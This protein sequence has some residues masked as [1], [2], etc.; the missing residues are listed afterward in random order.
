MFS[1]HSWKTLLVFSLFVFNVYSVLAGNIDPFLAE[2]LKS[3]SAV[4]KVS[5]IIYMREQVDLRAMEELLQQSVSAGERIPVDVRY[6]TIITALQEVAE[7]TQPNFVQKLRTHE[8]NGVLS[9]IQQFWI[10]NLVVVSAIQQTI[11]EI[12]QLPEVETVYLDGILQRD[13]PLNSAPADALVSGSEP[14]LRAIN[15]H[16]LWEIG[17][18]GLGRIVMNIDTGVEGNN[19]AYK[20]R[21]RGALPGIL[22]TWAWFD[23][24]NHTI[25]PTDGDGSS[26]HGTHTMGIMCGRYDSVNDTLGVA[27]D[28]NWIASNSLIGGSPHTSR[29]IASFQWAA[30]PDSNINTMD[31]VPDAINNSWYDPNV[32]STEC[33]GAS[34]YYDVIDAIEA[35]GTAVVFS[36]GN[37]GPG[38]STITPP[39]NR[40]TTSVNIFSV[41]ALDA[42]TAGYP[43]ASFSSRGPSVCTGPDS[44]RIKPEVSAPG[45]NVRSSSGTNGYRFLDGTSMAAPHVCGAIALLRQ[46]APFLTGTELKY[47]LYNNA[48][49]LGTPGED[50]TFGRGMIDV[51][52]TY[53]ALPLNIGKVEGEIMSNGNPLNGVKVDFVED[54]LQISSSTN[55][56]GK[57]LVAA[58]IDTPLTSATYTLRAEKF[59]FLTFT[60]TVTIL[61]DDTVTKNIVMSPAPGG[62]LQ[63]HTYDNDNNSI[64]ANVKVIFSGQTVINDIT[65]SISG[66]YSTPLPTGT[67]TVIIDAPSPFAT[68]SNVNVVVNENQTTQLNTLLRYV[69]EFTPIAIRDTL[70][71]GQI[72]SK[73]LQLTNTTN[74]TVQFRISDDNALQRSQKKNISQNSSVYSPI[75]FPKGTEDTRPGYASPEG[76]GGPDAFGYQWIDSDEPDGPEFQWID[77]SA[78]GT[79]LD[80]NST[81]IPTGTFSG[82]DEGYVQIPLSFPFGFYGSTFNTAYL[83]SNGIVMFKIPTSNT[84]SNAQIPTAGGSIDNLVA[85]FWDDLEI[86]GTSKIYYGTHSGNFVIQWMNIQRYNGNLAEYSYEYILKPSGEI[87]VQYLAMGISGGT[88]TSSTVGIENQTGTVGLQVAYNATYL[89][90]ELAIRFFTP[91]AIWISEVPITGTL[92]PHADQ[93]VSV[94]FNASGLSVDTTYRANLFL[95]A[96]HPDVIGSTK[97]PASLRIA[98]ADSA[99]LLVNK[100]SFDFGAVPLFETRKE[101]LKVTNGGMTTLIVSSLTTTNSDY[102][103]QPSNGTITTGN[104]INVVVSYHPTLSGIDTGR[105]IIQSNSQFTPR[106]DVL[107]NGSSY[108]VAR[109]VLHP[110]TFSFVSQATNDTLRKKMYILNTGSDTLRYFLEEKIANGATHTK[111]GKGGPDAFGYVWRDSDEPGGPDFLWYDIRSLGTAVSVANNGIA[112]PFPLGFDFKFYGTNYNEVRITGNGF[113]G[114]GTTSIGFSNTSIPSSGTPNNALFGFWEDLN[115]ETAGG[116]VHYFADA[117]NHLFIVQFTNVARA[118]DAGSRVTF[119]MILNANG[120]VKFQ[121]QSM[122]GVLNSATIGIENVTGGVGLLVAFNQNYVHDNL[123]ILFTTDQIPWLSQSRMEGTILPGDSQAVDI[124][125]HPARMMPG[126]FSARVKVQGNSPDTLLAQVNLEVLVGVNEI[127]SIIPKRFQ[128]FQNHPNPFNPTT[129]ISFGLPEQA[130]ISLQVFNVLGQEVVTLADG[131][132][133]AGTYNVEW[134]ASTALSSGIYFYRLKVTQSG[135]VRFAD[136]KKLLLLK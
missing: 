53:L 133:E 79:M 7:R 37:N 96:T 71:I 74:D 63:V 32:S 92:L 4:E 31:D 52:K 134:N 23:P 57:Y 135:N 35:L 10:R 61:L 26:Q 54:I 88:L 2:K 76:R 113:L 67:Y 93:N 62:T 123:A 90:N 124:R 97:I 106:L 21:W 60:D 131:I 6:R 13:L 130:N 132:F 80:S 41:G 48:V 75:E 105:I 47:Y 82:Q 36:A 114:F 126:N 46:A 8:T 39:K 19:L 81:W 110:N 104:S 29:S 14:G 27:P 73:Q 117:V 20:T 50:N 66:L 122:T 111:K 95:E 118:N 56:E 103:V 25:F 1:Y 24:A 16:K 40:L 78:T 28:A 87:V 45:V 128:L 86:V 17:I 99:L 107:L 18:T 5:V 121:Y 101:T 34:G 58:R 127:L 65:D 68:Y 115:P 49:D 116:E 85:G 70:A 55:A 43:I 102:T 30:N 11:E 125:V 69:V 12:A 91:D 129:I 22:P 112:G 59:G 100:S 72:H 77:I 38:A 15:A 51:W 9:D 120:D 3:T 42:N 64:R 109:I 94:T 83:S 108:G 84:Y 89:H 136:S 98:F 33:S 44:L 119:Q